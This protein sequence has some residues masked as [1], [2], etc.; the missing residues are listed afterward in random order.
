MTSL[1]ES[2]SAPSFARAVLP[3]LCNLDRLRHAMDARGLDGIVATLPNNVFYLTSFN[4]VAHK[5]DEPRP[6]AVVLARDA[7]EHPILVVADYYLATFLAQPTWILDI[8]PFRAVMMPLDLPRPAR[9]HRSLH[10]AE[11]GRRRPGSPGR[12]RPTPSTWAAPSAARL[13]DLKLDRGRVAFDDMGFGFRLGLEGL[14]VADG[15]DPL[16]VRAR[17]QDRGRDAPARARDAR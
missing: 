14:E 11:R 3:R 10:P 2:G 6:Y 4:G 15:Y 17:G 13:R 9:R 5:S 7:P 12:A 8:R 1:H 16:D